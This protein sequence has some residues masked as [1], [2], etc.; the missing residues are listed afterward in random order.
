MQVGHIAWNVEGS[1]LSLT[2]NLRTE[3]ANHT[4][5]DETAVQSLF[6]GMNEILLR[7]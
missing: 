5:S 4:G 2:V 3:T 6:V 1:D 7:L